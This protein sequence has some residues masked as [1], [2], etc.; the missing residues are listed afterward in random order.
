MHNIPAM[1]HIIH[2]KLH[3]QEPL[4]RV[5]GNRMVQKGSTMKKEVDTYYEIPL[6][7][8]I[9]C[10]LKMDTVRNQVCKHYNC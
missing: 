6:F 7:Q 9:Q 4:E 10:L 2:Q 5:L 3:V 1:G 8:S